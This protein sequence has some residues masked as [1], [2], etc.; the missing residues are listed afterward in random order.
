MTVLERAPK[1][2][3]VG[4]DADEG[5]VRTENGDLRADLVVAAD[6]I[7]SKVRRALFPVHPGPAYSGVW[8]CW[9]YGQGVD[10][11]ASA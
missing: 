10:V 1:I 4:M 7:H 6:G 11:T 8:N 2:H 9:C 5:I 3:P